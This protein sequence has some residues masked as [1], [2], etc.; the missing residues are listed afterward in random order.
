MSRRFKISQIFNK[1]LF[2]LIIFFPQESLSNECESKI[3]KQENTIFIAKYDLK[4]NKITFGTNVNI[5][6][7]IQSDVWGG[8]NYSF[9]IFACTAGIFKLKK[10]DRKETSLFSITSKGKTVSDIYVFNR[11]LK[12]SIEKVDSKFYTKRSGKNRCNHTTETLENGEKKMIEHEGCNAFDRLSVQ[13]DYQKKLESGKYN[14]KYF[15][16]DKGRERNYIFKLVDTEIINTIFG[17]TETIVIKRIIEGNKRSTL[18]WYAI[19]HGFVP[20]K[21][22]QYRK[23]T[24]KFTAYLTKYKFN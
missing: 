10:D 12:N 16:I 1:I 15:V 8:T 11:V 3:N 22:E 2:F 6:R 19:D 20:V 14:A 13:I 9:Q 21:I 5:Y 24:L 7:R 23:T 17:E 4:K 18:T